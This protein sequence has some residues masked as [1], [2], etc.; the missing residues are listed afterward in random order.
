MFISELMETVNA[1]RWE[2][3]FMQFIAHFDMYFNSTSNI[4]VANI[5]LEVTFGV[6]FFLYA[7][8]FWWRRRVRRARLG[9]SE[10]E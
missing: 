5:V 2:N 9:S 4:T 7:S 8:L 6:I 3:N 1:T 10:M